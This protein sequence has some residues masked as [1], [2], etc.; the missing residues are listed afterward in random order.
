M[1][2]NQWLSEV[3]QHLAL[4]C[5]PT[6]SIIISFDLLEA[7]TT[8]H[9]SLSDAVNALQDAI[10]DDTLSIDISGTLLILR[11]DSFTATPM[12]DTD[13]ESSEECK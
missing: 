5:S 1:Q 10:V 8:G 4:D 2:L 7:S 9:V 11:A 12:Y 3:Q 6:G 13:S